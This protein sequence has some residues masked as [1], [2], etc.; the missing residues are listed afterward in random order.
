M[1]AKTLV[2]DDE[3]EVR[4]ILEGFLTKKGY[5]VVTAASAMEGI[6]KLK[7]ENPKVILLDIEMPGMS[8]VEAIGKIREIDKNVG[9][10]MATGVKDEKIAQETVKLGASDYIV[11]PFDFEYMEKSLLVKLVSLG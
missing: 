6:E 4:D 5:K 8:G 9:I 10:I 11:K 3:K 2:I 7:A 1:E